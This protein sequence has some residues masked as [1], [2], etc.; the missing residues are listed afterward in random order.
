MIDRIND[1]HKRFGENDIRSSFLDGYF[2]ILRTYYCAYYH[3]E[4]DDILEKYFEIYQKKDIK[5]GDLGLHIQGHKNLLNSFLVINCWSN[6][7]LFISLFSSA[8]LTEDK[9]KELLEIDY[10]R[11][12]KILKESRISEHIDNKLKK[13]IKKH[14]TH[15]PMIN[16]FGKLFK[17][18]HPYPNDRNKK[19]DREFLEFFGRFRNCIHSNYI[20]FGAEGKDFVFNDETYSFRNGKLVSHAPSDESSIFR[21]TINLKEIFNVIVN[22]INYESEIYDPSVDLIEI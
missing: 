13:L 20:F 2:Q 14:I 16:K 10:Q 9:V 11:K 3:L 21:L 4:S 8:V 17:M 12:K 6:F 5:K 19:N 18:I 15:V 22:N 1:F 7:E